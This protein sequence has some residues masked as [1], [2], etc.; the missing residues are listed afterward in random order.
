ME[1]KKNNYKV[2]SIVL[3]IIIIL[4]LVAYLAFNKSSN[5]TTQSNLPTDLIEDN[6]PVLGASNASISIIEFSDFECVYC[7]QAYSTTLVGFKNSSY[8]KDGEVNLIFKQLPLVSIH[9]YS[10]KAAEAS[11]CAD[12]QGKFWEYHNLLFDNQAVLT[13]TL[14]T[15]SLNGVITSLKQYASQLKLDTSKF[16]KCL[17]DGKYVSEISKESNLGVALNI[18]GTPAFVIVN[19]Q[20]EMGL[21]VEGA[22]PWSNFEQAIN[23]IK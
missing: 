5:K 8:F 2:A 1:E 16:D 4:G 18:T 9:P 10:Q 20:T 11:L 12:E 15:G 13:S 3:V 6:D 17:D 7:E 19:K 23:E 22:Y 14:Q 21:L